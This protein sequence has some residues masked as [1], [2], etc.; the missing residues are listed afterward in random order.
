MDTRTTSLF[1]SIPHRLLNISDQ[2]ENPSL[3]KKP[4]FWGIG[5]GISSYAPI[6]SLAA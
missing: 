2:N 6:A 3:S 4:G 1:P 5:I